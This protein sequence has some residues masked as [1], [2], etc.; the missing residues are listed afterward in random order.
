[1]TPPIIQFCDYRGANLSS[2]TNAEDGGNNK[3]ALLTKLIG[4]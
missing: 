1:M 4:N 3:F 2:K